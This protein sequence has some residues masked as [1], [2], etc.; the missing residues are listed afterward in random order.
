[1]QLIFLNG[2]TVFPLRCASRHLSSNFRF[3]RVISPLVY[4]PKSWLSVIFFFTLL[5][6]FNQHCPKNNF[7]PLANINV[8]FCSSYSSIISEAGNYPRRNSDANVG[9]E[10]NYIS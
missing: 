6:S 2:F 9:D 4:H 5:N 10:V 8:D 1:M 7:M 3:G